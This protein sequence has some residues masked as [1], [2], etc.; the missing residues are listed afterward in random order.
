MQS[1]VKVEILYAMLLSCEGIK[2][3]NASKYVA[4]PVN[5][6]LVFFQCICSIRCKQLLSEA[7]IEM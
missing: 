4:L 7:K 1:S 5:G 6:Q 3:G 2:L